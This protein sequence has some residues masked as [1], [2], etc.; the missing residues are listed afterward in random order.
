MILIGYIED[1]ETM[2]E[3]I[4]RVATLAGQN[5]MNGYEICC[6]VCNTRYEKD[7]GGYTCFCTKTAQAQWPW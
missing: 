7:C 3:A 6:R 1:G 2:F 5:G 4:T